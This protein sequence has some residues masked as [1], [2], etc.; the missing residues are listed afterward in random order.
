[1]LFHSNLCH[2]LLFHKDSDLPGH[3]CTETLISADICPKDNQH[4]HQ[5]E[6][7]PAKTKIS[8]D[9]FGNRLILD[10]IAYS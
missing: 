4:E 2:N 10:L 6:H 5:Y 7:L 9:V 1:M 8:L 3:A